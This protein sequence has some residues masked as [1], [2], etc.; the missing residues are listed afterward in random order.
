MAAARRSGPPVS[1]SE[2]RGLAGL[3]PELLR[4]A[5]G[6]AAGPPPSLPTPD[7]PRRAR[8]VLGPEPLLAP[9]QMVVIETDPG[10][11]REIARATVARYLQLPNYTNN[12]R[13]LGFTDEDLAGG[14]S[15][16]LVDA[17]V[18][19]GTPEE[20]EAR[21]REHHEAGADHVTV[22]V[23]TTPDVTRPPHEQWRLL[24]PALTR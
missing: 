9:E 4:L 16:A 3:G 13:R 21:L 23:L 14:G 19:R 24:A 2:R 22:Q 15:D 20:I 18:A 10:R 1:W 7:H 17:L 8:R 11:A 12:L 6:G 5:A